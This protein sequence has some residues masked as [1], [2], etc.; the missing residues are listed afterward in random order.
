M[1]TPYDTAVPR[2]DPR[3]DYMTGQRSYEREEEEDERSR[4][5]EERWEQERESERSE[6]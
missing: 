2:F 6:S 5:E 4:A 3:F 1:S